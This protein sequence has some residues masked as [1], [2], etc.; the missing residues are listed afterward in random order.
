MAVQG[1]AQL[2]E[3]PIQDNTVIKSLQQLIR[4]N[5]PQDLQKVMD[6]TDPYTMSYTYA[7]VSFEKAPN[8]AGW[9]QSIRPNDT[10]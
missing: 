5:L 9:Q 3:P 6:S 1:E 8:G 2:T 4:H 10:T 7:K